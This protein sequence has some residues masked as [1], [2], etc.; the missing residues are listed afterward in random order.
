MRDK[1]K[2]YNDNFIRSFIYK[3]EFS[4]E[5]L[6]EF[7]QICEKLNCNKKETVYKS[8]QE[9]FDIQIRF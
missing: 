5:T 6:K 7:K 1:D 8:Q 9:L 4:S 3:N 2:L